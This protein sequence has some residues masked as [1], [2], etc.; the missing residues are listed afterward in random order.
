LGGLAEWAGLR[1]SDWIRKTLH[2]MELTVRTRKWTVVV[3][4]WVLSLIIVATFTHGQTVTVPSAIT[5]LSGSDIGFRVVRRTGGDH[6]M[7]NVVVRNGQWVDAVPT[8]AAKR[9]NCTTESSN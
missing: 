8:D 5:V 9:Q 6:V 4:L 3:V 2:E 7:G 1:L